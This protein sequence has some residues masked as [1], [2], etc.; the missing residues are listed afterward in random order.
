VASRLIDAL[1]HAGYEVQ[2]SYVPIHLLSTY[3]QCVW[4]RLPYAERVWADLV[5]LPCEP[6]VSLTDIE[7]IAAIVKNI[8]AKL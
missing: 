6:S 7:R 8:A 5:E 1:G 4:D 2:G 3:R